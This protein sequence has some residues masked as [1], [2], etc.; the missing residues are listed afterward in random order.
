MARRLDQQFTQVVGEQAAAQA[1]FMGRV[2]HG[3][4]PSARSLRRPL[5]SLLINGTA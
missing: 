1:I 2:G 4:Q 3:P 5:D